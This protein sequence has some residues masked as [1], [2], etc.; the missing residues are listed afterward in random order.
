MLRF[1]FA[2]EGGDGARRVSLS[3]AFLFGAG[4]QAIPGASAQIV[5][6]EILCSGPLGA[7]AGLSLEYAVGDRMVVLQTCLLPTGQQTY[8]LAMELARRRIMLLLTKIEEWGLFD[9]PHAREAVNAIDAARERLIAALA[10]GD[11]HARERDADEALS[12]AMSASESLVA[13]HARAKMRERRDGRVH[14]DAVAHAESISG[15]ET[16]GPAPA[17]RSPDGIGVILP[18][19]AAVGCTVNPARFSEAIA[20]AIAPACDF[21]T[22]P[23]RWSGLEPEEG[24][25]SFAHTDRWIEWAVRRAKIGV[26][27]GPIIDLSPGCSPDWLSIWENDYETLRELVYEHVR[28][29][30][31]RYRRTV[32]RW[33]IVSGLAVNDHF[34]LSYDKMADLTRI[35]AMVVRKLHPH[36]R[37]QVDVSHPWGEYTATNAGAIAPESYLQLLQQAVIDYDAIGLRI[38]QRAQG[39]QRDALALAELLDAYAAFDRPIHVSALAAPGSGSSGSGPNSLRGAWSPQRQA[40]WLESMLRVCAGTHY[41]QSIC[42]GELIDGEGSLVDPAAG[43]LEPTGTPKPALQSLVRWRRLI[44]EGGPEDAR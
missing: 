33:V 5:G 16:A 7:S 43:L 44:R 4:G 17:V 20:A 41:V 22:V 21:V 14:A 13:F 28:Q 34:E 6:S 19:V 32:S 27:A 23:M 2:N 3:S 40:D 36:A 8:S 15:G 26:V 42:W 9:D 35:C 39:P 18:G 30:V 37:I 31:T 1:R 12:L 11:P 25:Y 24:V 38:F 29:V 10:A